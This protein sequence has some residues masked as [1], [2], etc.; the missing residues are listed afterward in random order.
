MAKAGK[1]KGKDKDGDALKLYTIFMGLLVLVMA[2]LFFIIDGVRKEFEAANVE[3]AKFL[4]VEGE[5]RD[6]EELPT[7]IPDL[8]W[9]V[10]TLSKRYRRAS[11]G[12]AI[13]RSI[14]TAMMEKVATQARLEQ[15][16]ASGERSPKSGDYMTISQDFEFTG[17]GGIPA[18]QGQLLTLLWNIESRGEGRYR[19]TEV[20]WQV[21]EPKENPA[22]PFDKIRKPRIRVSLRVPILDE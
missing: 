1:R 5:D 4:E 10:D 11:G 18:T 13:G 8:A 14:P 22:A 7:T 3:V 19:V 9:E 16:Y 12:G 2:V 15:T 20:S 17:M 6:P 21:A